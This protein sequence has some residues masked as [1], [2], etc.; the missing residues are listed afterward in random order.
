MLNLFRKRNSA[1]DVSDDEIVAPADG[2]IIDVTSVSDP[3][4]SESK[5]GPEVAFQYSGS[6]VTL[7]A[8]ANGELSVLFPT[9]HAFGITMKNGVEI[10]V[11][12]GVDTVEAKG[13][14]FTLFDKKQGDSVK[15][16]EPIITVDLNKLKARYDMSTMLIIT[17]SNGQTF[18]FKGPGAIARG[19]SLTADL[20]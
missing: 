17:E 10:L 9:G 15:A 12:C 13:D 2:M 1:L 4:F 8:P 6:K 7:C 5:L 11:H 19:D 14:G 16:G 18:Q 20:H 3:I